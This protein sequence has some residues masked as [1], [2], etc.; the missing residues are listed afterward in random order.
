MHA[1]MHAHTHTDFVSVD[2]NM[3]CL[4]CLLLFLKVKS[5]F[6]LWVRGG[7]GGGMLN[8]SL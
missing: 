2:S 1:H 3:C 8:I 7:M 5:N 4:V 6:K